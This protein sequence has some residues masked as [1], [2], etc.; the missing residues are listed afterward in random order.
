MS[1]K[2]CSLRVSHLRRIDV[3]ERCGWVT[4][5]ASIAEAAGNAM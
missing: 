5:V 3:L 1:A 2:S 4:D